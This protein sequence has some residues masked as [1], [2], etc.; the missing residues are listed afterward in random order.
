MLLEYN[1]PTLSAFYK[2]LTAT[3][4]ASTA[5][6]DLFSL[7]NKTA[8]A[9]GGIGGPGLSM[10]FALAEA[11]ANIISIQPPSDPS[12]DSLATGVRD[13]NRSFTA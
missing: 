7:T 9:T 6:A 13:L 10:T 12:A 3:A 5:I 11:D 4:P 8:I 1:F 2:L